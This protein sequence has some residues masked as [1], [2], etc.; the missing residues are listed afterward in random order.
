MAE[1]MEEVPASGCFV[2]RGVDGRYWSDHGWVDDRREAKRF[3]DGPDPW[4]GARRA[5]DRL[6]GRGS[7]CEVTFVLR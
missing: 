4:L 1:Q 5:A 7:P 2:I 3:W 6:S